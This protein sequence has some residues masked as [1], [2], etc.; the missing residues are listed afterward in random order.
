MN[1]FFIENKSKLES[2]LRNFESLDNTKLD[3]E[4]KILIINIIKDMINLD[5][6]FDDSFDLCTFNINHIG[7]SFVNIIQSDSIEENLD[8][9]ISQIVRFSKEL[10]LRTQTLIP[11]VHSLLNYY[12]KNQYTLSD[13][14]GQLYYALNVMPIKIAE[15]KGIEKFREIQQNLTTEVEDLITKKLP[16][17]QEEINKLKSDSD[18]YVK[19]LKGFKQEFSFLSLDQAFNGLEVRKQNQKKFLILFL[20]I[21]GT[22]IIAIPAYFYLITQSNFFDNIFSSISLTVSTT[23]T[24]A[25][26][27]ASNIYQLLM[28]IIPVAFIESILIYY[29]RILLNQYNSTND[30]IIQLETKQAIMQFIESYVDYKKDKKLD[31]SDMLKFEEIIFSQ[32]SPNL[33]DV[34]NS[35]DLVSLIEGISKAIKSK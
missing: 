1:E 10:E 21:L 2:F 23:E 22:I 4:N 28:N 24:A 34:P 20:I 18:K 25:S 19:L 15:E 35:P 27:N 11:S 8:K 16:D 13:E 3:L 33:K 29:F 31:H 5:N 17:K 6:L 7:T 9:F 12:A 30:Q 26:T 32:I 14:S